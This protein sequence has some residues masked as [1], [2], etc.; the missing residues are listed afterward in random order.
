MCLGQTSRRVAVALGVA[1]VGATAT[2]SP[3]GASISIAPAGERSTFTLELAPGASARSAV[4]ILNRGPAERTVELA[5]ASV[6]TA[7]TGGLTYLPRRDG[8]P[9]S[10]IRLASD[11]VRVPAGASR[12]VPFS[13]SAPA[14]PGTG[15]RYAGITATDSDELTRARR[16]GRAGPAMTRLVRYAVPIRVRLPGPREAVLVA[17]GAVARTDAAGRSVVLPLRSTG[18]LIIHS[19]RADLRVLRDGRTIAAARA[20]LGQVAPGTSFDFAIPLPDVPPG[21]YEVVGT[22]R[23]EGAPAVRIRER[24]SFGG[25]TPAGL[26]TRL[27][28]SV[29]PDGSSPGV[30]VGVATAIGLATGGLTLLVA[31]V[32]R[33]RRSRRLD[34]QLAELEMALGGTDPA[35]S[36]GGARERARSRV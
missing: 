26:A 19:S 15:D 34:V 13:V 12:V 1:V 30:Q 10:W 7:A 8:D 32:R 5:P 22:I 35:V 20:D 23:P 11:R 24:V 33:R 25:G 17:D 14:R 4:E 36:A 6:G 18:T 16:A 3:A 2:P 27:R 28:E 31:H 21:D 9:S 29:L